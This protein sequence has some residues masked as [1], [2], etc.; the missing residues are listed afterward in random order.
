MLA[1]P[2]PESPKILWLASEDGLEPCCAL[3]D[4]FA[5]KPAP[6]GFGG[7]GDCDHAS[8]ILLTLVT[9]PFQTIS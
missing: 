7:G 2:N 4:A 5:S 3:G 1:A 8:L 6:T 9:C